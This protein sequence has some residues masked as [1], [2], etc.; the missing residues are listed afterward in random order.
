MSTLRMVWNYLPSCLQPFLWREEFAL[1]VL[2][3][4]C[5]RKRISTLLKTHTSMN[6]WKAKVKFSP[7][8]WTIAWFVFNMAYSDSTS[9]MLK[10]I[11]ITM[12]KL[13]FSVHLLD[14]RY[15]KSI[16]NVSGVKRTIFA[17]TS[18]QVTFEAWSIELPL[19]FIHVT[20]CPFRLGVFLSVKLPNCF[21]FIQ[22]H[23][24]ST[25]TSV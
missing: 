10:Y 8:Q 2:S 17:S 7:T 23:N 9:Q 25:K 4:P 21:C 3:G 16:R 1:I 20:L 6:C 24:D 11:Y 12:F 22:F 13:P 14:A 15:Q 19:S 18:S 5:F